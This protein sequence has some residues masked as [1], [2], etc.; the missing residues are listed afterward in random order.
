MYSA[1]FAL[2]VSY[3]IWYAGIRQLGTARASMYSNLVPIVAMLS[4][5]FV[6]QEP[7]GLRKIVGAGAVLAGVALTRIGPKSLGPPQE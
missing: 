4:A 7:L 6:L 1:V 5:V 3:T 2:C